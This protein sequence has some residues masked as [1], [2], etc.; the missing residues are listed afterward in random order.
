[1]ATPIATAIVMS[2][3]HVIVVGPISSGLLVA[4]KVA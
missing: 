3:C 1:M 2:W 4:K